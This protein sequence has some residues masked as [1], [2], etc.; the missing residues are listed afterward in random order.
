[1]AAE[2]RRS[3]LLGTTMT[4]MT[5]TITGTTLSCTELEAPL[6]TE[7]LLCNRMY[8]DDYDNG[9]DN[10][11]RGAGLSHALRI[12]RSDLAHEMR[13]RSNPFSHALR[14]KKGGFES[15]GHALRIRSPFSHSLRIKKMDE[16]YY[17][18]PLVRRAMMGMNLQHALRVRRSGYYGDPLELKRGASFSHVLRV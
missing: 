10:D 15:F 12:R 9:I 5:T 1:M 7:R 11:K 13:L 14:I 8:F 4:P 6:L 17:Y 2:K 16:D 18:E 3:R